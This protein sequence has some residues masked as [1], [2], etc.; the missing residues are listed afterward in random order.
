[1]FVFKRPIFWALWVLVSTVT[2]VWRVL[3]EITARGP[4]PSQARPTAI[5]GPQVVLTA[6][7]RGHHK[8]F[9]HVDGRSFQVLVDT[10]ASFVALTEMDAANLGFR[11]HPSDKAV[12]L[13]TANGEIHGRRFLIPKLSIGELSV[14]DVDAVVL[15]REALGISLLGQSFLKRLNGYELSQGRLTLRG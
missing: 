13:R 8:T 12:V 10:G 6:D 15:P 14:R 4:Q 9:A 3:P 7:S 2:G 11:P 5:T 1:M